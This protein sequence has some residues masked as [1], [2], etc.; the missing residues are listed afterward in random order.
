MSFA[1]QQQQRQSFHTERKSQSRSGYDND[2]AQSQSQQSKIY[3]SRTFYSSN[4][5]GTYNYNNSSRGQPP[6]RKFESNVIRNNHLNNNDGAEKNQQQFSGDRFAQHS[7]TNLFRPGPPAPSVSSHQTPQESKPTNPPVVQATAVPVAPARETPAQKI[8]PTARVVQQE[9]KPKKPQVRKDPTVVPRNKTQNMYELLKG[10]ESSSDEESEVE[11]S[12]TAH[13]AADSVT[14]VK[15]PICAKSVAAPKEEKKSL[16]GSKKDVKVPAVSPSVCKSSEKE[17]KKVINEVLKEKAKNSVKVSGRPEV[18]GSKKVEESS[19]KVSKSAP[20]NAPVKETENEKPKKVVKVSTEERVTNSDES[21]KEAIDQNLKNKSESQMAQPSSQLSKEEKKKQKKQRQ[22]EKAART[23]EEKFCDYVGAVKKEISLRNFGQ[24]EA[25]ITEAFNM[26][27]KLDQG[28]ILY[29]LRSRMYLTQEKYDLA[30]KD[31][32]KLL[33]KN[34]ADKEKLRTA[35]DCCLK[36]GNLKEF[37][38]FSKLSE[39]SKFEFVLAA[40]EKM[41]KLERLL[42][43]TKENE[44]KQLFSEAGKFVREGL[45]MAPYSLKL[46]YWKA[47]LEALDKKSNDARQTLSQSRRIELK[48]KA[49]VETEFHRE[50]VL[51]LCSFYEG[52]IKNAEVRFRFALKEVNAAEDWFLKARKMRTLELTVKNMT[53]DR[54]YNAALVEAQKGLEVGE[55]NEKYLIK[56]LQQKANIHHRLGS[57]ESAIDCLNKVIEMNPDDDESLFHRGSIHLELGDY[58]AAVKDLTSAYRLD[59][60][61]CDYRE[62]LHRAEKLLKKSLANDTD[63]YKILGVE[64]NAS[65]ETI[66]K[67]FKKK[68][69]ECHPDKHANSTKEVKEENEMKMKELSQAYR[70]HSAPSLISIYDLPLLCFQLSL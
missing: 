42:A 65:M 50:F 22:R 66:K 69:L 51:G 68:A 12:G 59:P 57:K 58:E 62:E 6:M 11:V 13:T 40:K 64:R 21:R 34:K 24:A 30:L 10:N 43:A 39:G 29:E 61:C 25:I 36:T 20:L 7:S 23:N 41:T 2:A 18:S 46:Y 37:Q 56:M 19:G 70:Y 54:Q 53:A 45:Q 32:K 44:Q 26:S 52:D 17:T 48:V 5:P 63:Y 4:Y 49:A 38:F 47:K 67:A 16:K 28:N 60:C 3:H 35:M 33:E 14:Q 1:H 31:L 8:K 27:F 15:T 9:A 55:G